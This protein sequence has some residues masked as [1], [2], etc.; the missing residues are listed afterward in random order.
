MAAEA[1]ARG[2]RLVVLGTAPD[3]ADAARF[4]ALATA[5]EAGQDARY[6]L[7]FSDALAR[8]I[9]AGADALLVPSRYEP[10]GL[11]QLIALRYGTIPIV[12]RTGGLADTVTDIAD[13][14]AAE[15]TRNGVVFDG[16]DPGAARTAVVRALDAYRADA[17]AW[18]RGVLVPRAAGQ[19]WSWSRSSAAYLD[20]YRR[21]M[22]MNGV[23]G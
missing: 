4:A 11:A 6:R 8:R 12:R 18:W 22:A 7:C 1:Q 13:G 16:L 23:R 10:C 9:Y 17:G 19:D 3:P 5:A 21:A 2:A 15:A 14:C 20:V